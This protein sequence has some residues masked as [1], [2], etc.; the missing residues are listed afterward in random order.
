MTYNGW[1]N[2]ATWRVNL[3]IA[4]DYF[5][6]RDDDELIDLKRRCLAGNEYDVVQ[7]LREWVSDVLDSYGAS[8]TLLRNYADSFI[9]DVDFYEI[10]RINL[11]HVIVPDD[12]T[13][14]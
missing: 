6:T 9:E 14:D 2:Y 4:H 13:D 1:A 7:I 11:D 5:E 12:K 8:G 10:V 3:E